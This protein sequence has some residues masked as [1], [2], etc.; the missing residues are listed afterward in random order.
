MAFGPVIDVHAASDAVRV[1]HRCV[2]LLEEVV[3]HGDVCVDEDEDVAL[4]MACPCVPGS[5]NSLNR[6]ADYSRAPIPGDGRG[7]VPAV[8][9]YDDGVDVDVG[10]RTQLCGCSLDRVQ[11][12]VQVGL[13]VEGRDDDRELRGR[14]R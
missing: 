8:V 7:L 3:R 13:F 12:R 5:R 4:G 6:F 14:L 1:A 2:D 10:A 9:V 11:G